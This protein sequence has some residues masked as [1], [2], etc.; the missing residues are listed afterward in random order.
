MGK[1]ET[2]SAKIPA[3]VYQEFT[4]RIP[5]GERSNFIRDAIY[6]KLQEIPRPDRISELELRIASLE[7]EL[8]KIRKYL[9]RLEALTY[10]Q[11][12]INPHVFGID[13][14]DRQI[15]DHLI[16]YKG[17]TTPELAEQT[18]TNRWLILNRLRRIQKTSKEQLGK[19]IIEYYSGVKMGKKK[20]WWLNQE[21]VES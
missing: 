12:R 16:H 20:A 14:I 10:E 4:L 11:G 6:E 21:L 18:D 17:A 15:I 2:V 5:R 1:T 9:V 7:A 3:E 8:P 19:P 13:E